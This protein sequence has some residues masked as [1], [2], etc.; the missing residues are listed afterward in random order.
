MPEITRFCPIFVAYDSACDRSERARRKLDGAR[1]SARSLPVERSW[2]SLNNKAL[3]KE[4][5]QG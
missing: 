1:M 5:T 4:N 2:A 3:K